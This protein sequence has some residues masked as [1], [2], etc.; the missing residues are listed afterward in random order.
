MNDHQSMTGAESPWRSR[1]VF[2]FLLLGAF[3]LLAAAPARAATSVDVLLVAASR[4][5]GPV[6]PALKKYQRNL[7]RILR[8]KSF[9]LLDAERARVSS[10]GA[11]VSLDPDMRVSIR[12]IG[13]NGRLKLEIAWRSG[14][15]IIL[16]TQVSIKSGSPAILGGARRGE[17]TLIMI[18]D[19]SG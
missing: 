1:R 4:E 16:R 9:E 17:K 18:V 10:D 15:K 11:S 3:A 13:N 6:D 2:G 19:E 8:F 12:E 14:D 7:E 5:E